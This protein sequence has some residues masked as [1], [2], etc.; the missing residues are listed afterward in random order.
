MLYAMS[1][2]SSFLAG[3]CIL[4]FSILSLTAEPIRVLT[5]FAPVD[6]LT[7][8]VVGDAAKVEMLLPSGVGPHDFALSPGDLKR[9]A[10]ADVI[11]MNGLDLESWLEKPLKNTA[12]KEVLVIDT[13]RGIQT[14]GNM[15]AVGLPS[16]AAKQPEAH[17][18]DHDDHS[19]KGHDHGEINPHIWLDPIFAIAQVEAIRDGM[20]AKDPT[21]AA[22]YDANAKAYSEQLHKLDQDIRD[23]TSQLTSHNLITFHDAFVYFA[24]RYGF[25]IV[26]V[27]EPFPGKEPSPKYLKQLKD[28]IQEKEVRVLF[29]EPQYSPSVMNALAKDLGIAVATLD[30][31]ET[32]QPGPQL[33][34]NTMRANLDSLKASLNA[35]P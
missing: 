1:P 19:H 11:V 2:F 23:T 29:C 35:Q 33:Y 8:N 17:S 6:S 7:R 22:A 26:G 21:K 14:S 4:F 16:D 3:L 12:K 9:I 28:T 34:E 15:A 25:E 31:M 18:H 5:T 10:E 20:K 24:K 13:S 32:G 27:F 30:T